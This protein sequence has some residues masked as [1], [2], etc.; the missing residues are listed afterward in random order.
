MDLSSLLLKLQVADKE[1]LTVIVPTRQRADLLAYMRKEKYSWLKWM[2]EKGF[3][4]FADDVL[5]LLELILDGTS[6]IGT[7]IGD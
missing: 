3:L 6:W 4:L 2:F 5:E 1:D 7:R